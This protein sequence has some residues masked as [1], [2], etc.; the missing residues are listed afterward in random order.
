M[1]A[2]IESKDG[3][4]TCIILDRHLAPRIG[5][6][7]FTDCLLKHHVGSPIITTSRSKAHIQ[8]SVWELCTVNPARDA[9]QHAWVKH[10]GVCLLTTILSLQL[11]GNEDVVRQLLTAVGC[12][13]PCNT[14]FSLLARISID[15][16][17]LKVQPAHCTT[18][19][20]L[21]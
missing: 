4:Q 9:A 18:Y 14:R 15:P 7:I 6:I 12:D 11:K 13:S 17:L 1:V 21:L 16:N 3:E 20:F 10:H 8:L 5:I 19:Q 2:D